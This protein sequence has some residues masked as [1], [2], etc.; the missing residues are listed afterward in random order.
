MYNEDKGHYGV[1]LP[2]FREDG[3]LPEGH[4]T[5]TWE[6][7]SK[8]F[9]GAFGSHRAL[10]LAQL[11]TWRDAARGVGLAGRMLLNG[12]FIST[13]VAPGD[14]DAL[15]IFDE[16]TEERLKRDSEARELVNHARIKE[17]GL[18]DLFCF[19]EATVR[20]FP[21]LCRLDGFDIDKETGK[22]K[23]VVEVVL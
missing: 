23:G 7:I 19:A 16:Q 6:E 12:S 10:L 17:S 22:A 20:R 14:V 8:V 1:G 9:G 13:K 21:A 5:T 2:A 4:H 15:F 18:G 11:L 3:W